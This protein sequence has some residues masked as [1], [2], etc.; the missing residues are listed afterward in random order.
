MYIIVKAGDGLVVKRQNEAERFISKEIRHQVSEWH[1]GW[2]HL[3][4]KWFNG[5]ETME[6]DGGKRIK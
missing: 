6:F 3:D 2:L 5:G 4:R 1:K